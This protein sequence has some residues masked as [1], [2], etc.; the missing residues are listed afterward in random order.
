MCVLSPLV[1]H[2]PPTRPTFPRNAFPLHPSG[3]PYHPA[4]P[5]YRYYAELLN[6]VDTGAT[7]DVS[8]TTVYTRYDALALEAV[9]GTARAE[10]MLE[11]DKDV[12]M[13]M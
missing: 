13:F 3:H 7:T 1:S 5:R 8:C 11:S 9:L 12:H 6:L 10:R 2:Y 4:N